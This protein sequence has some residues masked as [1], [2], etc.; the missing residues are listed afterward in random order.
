VRTWLSPTGALSAALVGLAI[1]FGAGWRG[2]VLLLVFFVTA[3]ALTPG[4]GRRRPVQVFANGGVAAACALLSR[5]QPGFAA[6]FAGALAAAAADTWSTE[7]GGRS[8]TAPR[9]ITTWRSVAAGASGGVTLLGVAGG[10][11]G[12]ALIAAAASLLGLTQGGTALWI[13]AGGAAGTLVDSL[14]GATLQARWRCDA[15]GAL[16]ETRRDD[17]G[18]RATPASGLPWLDND[19]VNLAATLLGAIVA[20][21]PLIV[22]SPAAHP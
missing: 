14:L 6:A 22:S 3:S 9:L 13:A 1:W 12:A 5:W 16:I 19:A 20:L 15:C 21:L 10:L 2:L 11:A 7:I 17:C 8:T 18:G 4:G